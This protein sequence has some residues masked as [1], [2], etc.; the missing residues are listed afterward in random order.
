MVEAF[1]RRDAV[2]EVQDKIEN[3]DKKSMVIATEETYVG[4]TIDDRKRKETHET[5]S[6]IFARWVLHIS[7]GRLVV[8]I[9]RR[10]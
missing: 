2:A 9:W 10:S 7:S 1:T 5:C 3:K 4:Y 8:N 6:E